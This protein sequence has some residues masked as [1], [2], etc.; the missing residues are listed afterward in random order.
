MVCAVN[1]PDAQDQPVP[2]NADGSLAAAKA[3]INH[4]NCLSRIQDAQAGAQDGH[5]WQ[6][7]PVW[8]AEMGACD[9]GHP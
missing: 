8:H 1:F 5:N 9:P 3:E 4:G 2:L 6:Y 7:P